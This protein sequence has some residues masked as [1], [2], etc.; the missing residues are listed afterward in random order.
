M[1]KTRHSI[2]NTSI[3]YIATWLCSPQKR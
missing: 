3:K 1:F 2:I